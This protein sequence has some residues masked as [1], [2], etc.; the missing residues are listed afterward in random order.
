MDECQ[1]GPGQRPR[2]RWAR[3][4]VLLGSIGAGLWLASSLGHATAAEA[5]APGP[6]CCS[7]R[8]AVPPLG[9]SPTGHESSD[10]LLDRSTNSAGSAV[11]TLRQIVLPV[12]TLPVP[13][14]PVL[15]PVPPLPVPTQLTRALPTRGLSVQPK[16]SVP[17]RSVRPMADRLTGLDPAVRIGGTARR[18]PV[19][20]RCSTC[21][22]DKGEPRSAEHP[23]SLPSM[24]AGI[25][26]GGVNSG[27]SVA[28]MALLAPA[29][30]RRDSP[31]GL[32]SGSA[33]RAPIPRSRS[34]VPTTRPG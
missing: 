29:A 1:A 13:P 4:V 24:P 11:G 2:S 21:R 23:T 3:R 18:S 9:I 26:S 6:S 17:A 27:S 28:A 5:A 22:P 31:P 14:Q 25:P 10:D 20:I 8:S 32:R 16:H 15:A 19:P 7:T 12:R 34:V 30:G 33:G